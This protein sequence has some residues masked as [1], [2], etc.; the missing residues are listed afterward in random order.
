MKLSEVMNLSS[1]VKTVVKTLKA[2]Y[3]DR[4]LTRHDIIDSFFLMSSYIYKAWKNGLEKIDECAYASSLFLFETLKRSGLKFAFNV[5]N[6]N[7]LWLS[8]KKLAEEIWDILNSLKNEQ[9]FKEKIQM[10][11]NLICEEYTKVI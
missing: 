2:F 9:I 4:P 7:Q 10:I 6:T 1:I 8:M 11:S 5:D 3:Q